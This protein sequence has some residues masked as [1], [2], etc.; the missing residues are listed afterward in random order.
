MFEH[1]NLTKEYMDKII[2]TFSQLAEHGVLV[3]AG[4]G[5]EHGQWNTMTAAWA[6]AGYLWNKPCAVL[7]IRPQRYTADFAEQEDYLS[8][9]FLDCTDSKMQ[10]ALHICGTISGRDEDKA[11]RAGITPILHDENLIGFE[12]ALLTVSCRKLYRSQFDMDLFLDPQVITD[13]YPKK[14]FHYVYFCELRDAY[15]K[16]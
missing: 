16:K 13:C 7:F 4:Y 6:L 9:S 10:E 5:I 11:Q 1:E 14:D 2:P 15:I 12:E 3:T 8:V